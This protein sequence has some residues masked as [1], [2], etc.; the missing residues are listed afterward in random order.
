MSIRTALVTMSRHARLGGEEA[1]E[2]L[3]S[4]EVEE[5]WS[6]SED[7][8]DGDDTYLPDPLETAQME[9]GNDE[10]SLHDSDVQ[11]MQIM[12]DT[13]VENDI[14]TNEDETQGNTDDETQS[15]DSGTD[16]SDSEDV[17]QSS[18]STTTT[19]PFAPPQFTAVAG[20]NH[21]L[22]GTAS[23][24][25]FFL[26]IFGENFFQVL[27]EQCNLY[28][29]QNPPG[30]S[31]NW[32]DTSESEMKLFMGIHLAMGVHKLPCVEDYWS[33]HPLL[34]APGVI[35]GM[36][37]RRFKAL[38]CCLHLNDNS[39]AKKRGE[40]GYDKLHK[41]RPML[42]SVRENCLWYCRLHREVSVD[43]AMVGFK[44]RSS[45]KQYCP[46]KPTKRGY[47]VWVQLTLVTCTT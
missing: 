20:P 22:P 42:E 41:V 47:T 39:T 33:Q 38:Q 44:G 19:A 13:E 46:M 11:Q 23:V 31:Y 2:L 27:A 37:V 21:N 25:E 35:Q 16:N 24:E 36:P 6:I 43:E 10:Q 5:D 3:D 12:S 45:M 7:E 8:D 30:S 29:R 4:S 18:S 14:H 32:V 34:G 28:A 40:S 15:C 26:L 1:L 17:C 9:E